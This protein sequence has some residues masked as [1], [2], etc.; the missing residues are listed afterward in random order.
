LTNDADQTA[1]AVE[2]IAHTADAWR[3]RALAAEQR[4]AAVERDREAAIA[5]LAELARILR[6]DVERDESRHCDCCFRSRRALKATHAEVIPIRPTEG[7]SGMG[8]SAAGRGAGSRS[9]PEQDA[10]A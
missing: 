10:G 2:F 9:E 1:S 6:P 4:M 7:R 3:R 5:R 8:A